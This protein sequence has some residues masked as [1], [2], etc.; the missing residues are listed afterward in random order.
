MSLNYVVT[1]GEV[2]SGLSIGDYYDSILVSG[3]TTNETLVTGGSMTVTDSDSLAE[4]NTVSGSCEM[5]VN[6]GGR[7]VDTDLTGR[8]SYGSAYLWL[9]FGTATLTRV[10]SGG[11]FTMQDGIA[12][13]TVVQ[14]GGHFDIYGGTVYNAVVSETGFLSNYRGTIK[15][16]TVT[17]GGD[18]YVMQGA[19]AS[20]VTI[21]DN[22]HLFVSYGGEVSGTVVDKQG[23]LSISGAYAKDTVVNSGG[24]FYQTEGLA[25]GVTVNYG[26][27]YSAGFNWYGAPEDLTGIGAQNVVENGGNVYIGSGSRYDYES[28]TYI[29]GIL[30]PVT[31]LSNSFSGLTY[32]NYTYGTVHSGT[33]ATDITALAGGLT[34]YSGGLVAGYTIGYDEDGRDEYGY[35][36]VSAGHIN[37]Y[38]GGTATGIVATIP[39]LSDHYHTFFQFDIAP[40]TVISGSYNGADF[41]VNNGVTSDATFRYA[42]LNIMSGGTAANVTQEFGSGSAS[43]GATVTN[44]TLSATYFAVEKDAVVNGVT[45]VAVPVTS[46]VYTGVPWEPESGEW[47]TEEVMMGASLRVSAGARVTGMNLDA[48]SPLTV[49]MTSETVVSGVS[50]GVDFKMADGYFADATLNN[51]TI[52]MLDGTVENVVVN[53]G[54]MISAGGSANT[55]NITENGGAVYLEDDWRDVPFGTHT[56]TSNTFSGMTLNGDV[57]VH[58]NTI[59][60][61]NFMK[62]GV[63]DVY[64][65]GIVRDFW[66]SG[67]GMGMSIVDFHSGALGTN[68]DMTRYFKRPAHGGH[69]GFEEGVIISGLRLNTDDFVDMTVGATTIII[70]GAVDLKPF[71]VTGGVLSGYQ[72]GGQNDQTTITSG[73]KVIDSFFQYG[74]LYLQNGGTAENITVDTTV[75]VSSGS[76]LRNAHLGVVADPDNEE[77]EYYYGGGA[78]VYVNKGGTLDGFNMVNSSYVCVSSGGK[79][80]GRMD[81]AS[82][83][84]TINVSSGGVVDFNLTTKDALDGARLSDFKKVQGSPKYTITVDST[85]QAAGSYVLAH[86]AYNETG[87][88]YFT[89]LG[90]N[91]EDYGYFE[92]YFTTVWYPDDTYQIEFMSHFAGNA[93][94]GF[95]YG[96]TANRIERDDGVIDFDLVFT[97]ESE[98]APTAWFEAPTVTADCVTF[99]NAEAVNLT[100]DF[101]KEVVSTEYSYNGEDW[102]MLDGY[103]FAA[104][105]NATYFFRGTDADGVVS[106]VASYTVSNIDYKAPTVA[107]DLASAVDE[108]TVTLS[109]T[110]STDDYAGVM[111]FNVSYWMDGELGVVTEFTPGTNLVLDEMASGTWNWTVTALDYAGNASEAVAGGQF[112]VTNGY[113]PRID[114]PDFLTGNFNGGSADQ[115][116][117][118]V[119]TDNGSFAA[120]YVDGTPWGNG[121][122]VDPGWEIAGIGDFNADGQDDFLRI[123]GEGYVVGEMTQTDGTFVAQVL[124]FK[125]AGWDILGTGDFNG[126]GS[127]DVLIANPT[128]ASDTVGLLGYWESGVTW[129]LINGYSAEWEC[130]ATGDYNA[131]GKCDMLWR[132]SFVGDGGLIYNAYCTWIVDD[133]VDWRMVSVA[134]PQEWNYLCSGDF[135][136]DGCNDIAMINGEGVVG[137]WGVEDG[138]LSS[139]SILSAVNTDEWKLVGVGDFNGDGTDDIAWCSDISGLAG[140][141]QI[142][143]KQLTT[144]S[145]LANLA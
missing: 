126:N 89:V 4:K 47:V 113:I 120:I 62:Q 139:W 33:T 29:S 49:Y 104:E 67:G 57:T 32:N 98:I 42:S 70:N 52:F 74:S 94:S 30:F 65:G 44:L 82:D 117:T 129:T 18:I 107:A 106:D 43:A 136:S 90:T 111:G 141:W 8:G 2:S 61:S 66:T 60:S 22:G 37:V 109:W 6:N 112:V 83:G 92:S 81:I 118:V 135:N 145:N 56:F 31:F 77:S 102:K 36:Q 73:G 130:I 110:D 93:P 84:G 63:L 54:A 1:A 19:V 121:L 3:G 131:D 80:T 51:T 35:A 87:Y 101:S 5:Y 48:D 27:F 9:N 108:S 100:L 133:P 17:N 88:M 123:N 143:D 40:D 39:E 132:N 116:A 140:Y 34:V 28:Q 26:G 79:V 55:L 59:A 13:D 38:S 85:N 86:N 46:E 69:A 41:T 21:A 58:R 127:D 119:S 20:D 91:G 138:W 125:S 72:T 115:M 71:S 137:I 12:S 144:W 23:Q 142:N 95:S 53:N 103:V 64:D 50:G 25:D 128:G 96:L 134:N 7:I 10:N 105:V 97:V 24:S 15:G 16:A 78:D 68:I 14:S 75:Y 114:L 122:A 124:N 11:Y 99:T 76:I 45:G